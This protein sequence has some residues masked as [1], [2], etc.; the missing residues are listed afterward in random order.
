M[1]KLTTT[2]REAGKP[3]QGDSV[4]VSGGLPEI[5]DYLGKLDWQ[6]FRRG[7]KGHCIE[8]VLFLAEIEGV[9]LQLALTAAGG[10]K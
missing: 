4:E 1:A 6:E 8:S 5:M 7:F 10:D 2:I 3:H 9:K